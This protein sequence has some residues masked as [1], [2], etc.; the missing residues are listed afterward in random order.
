M[1]IHGDVSVK[2][3]KYLRNHL[4]PHV[5]GH[6]ECPI[7]QSFTAFCF[8]DKKIPFPQFFC[9]Y[10]KLSKEKEEEKNKIIDEWFE[11]FNVGANLGY[12]LKNPQENIAK[13]LLEMKKSG[14]LKQFD[15]KKVIDIILGGDGSSK[16]GFSKR[17]S[18]N[19]VIYAMKLPGCDERALHL[20]LV[21]V[22]GS[23]SYELIKDSHT[24]I[25]DAL[26]LQQGTKSTLDGVEYT[27]NFHQIG[28]WKYLRLLFGLS[29]AAGC[30]EFCVWDFKKQEDPKTIPCSNKRTGISDESGQLRPPL[31]SW[32]D[33]GNLRQWT[34]RFAAF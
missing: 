22:E 29:E 4:N 32:I 9:S 14:H 27:L 26:N 18:N 30:K 20:P 13:Y 15:E 7:P 5:A 21:F 17:S 19:F 10:D 25:F 12:R 31:I 24:P 34:S 6:K 11:K 23:E 28:D 1:I 16:G 2:S 8:Q 33:K 3:F